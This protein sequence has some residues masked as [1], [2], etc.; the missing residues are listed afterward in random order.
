VKKGQITKKFNP[1]IHRGIPSIVVITSDAQGN[2]MTI[3]SRAAIAA[4]V[5]SKRQ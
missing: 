4:N 3:P 2:G 1:K 5:W